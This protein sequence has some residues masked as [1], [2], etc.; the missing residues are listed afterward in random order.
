MYHTKGQ[1]WGRLC[2]LHRVRFAAVHAKRGTQ[3]VYL[4]RWA[5]CIDC[6]YSMSK[7][8]KAFRKHDPL[9]G[10]QH[11]GAM[12][13]AFRGGLLSSLGAT[14]LTSRGRWTTVNLLAHCVPEK[15]Y[16][17]FKDPG[18]QPTDIN[19]ISGGRLPNQ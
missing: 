9:Q 8:A 14:V 18:L 15:F 1:V 16:G 6:I 3:Q 2:S 12:R 13:S 11:T 19:S 4:L 10:A 5:G 7:T 17:V